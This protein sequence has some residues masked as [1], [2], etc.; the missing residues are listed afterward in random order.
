MPKSVQKPIP[1]TPKKAPKTGLMVAVGHMNASVGPL[2]TPEQ[3]EAALH[4]G[5]VDGIS[6]K[7][8]VGALI[9]SIFV[10]CSPALILRCAMETHASLKSVARLYR[11]SLE[12]GGFPSLAWERS[13][14]HLL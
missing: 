9:L 13:T 14:G 11:E 5:T 10:E 8:I 12:R 4:A 3:M 6:E 1:D 7:P 2:L